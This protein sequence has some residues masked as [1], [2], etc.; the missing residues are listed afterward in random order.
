MNEV[1]AQAFSL[2]LY[3]FK[4]QVWLNSVEFRQSYKAFSLARR[5][6][7]GWLAGWLGGWLAGYESDYSDRSSF[8]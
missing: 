8:A 5:L 3:E 4:F 7:S 1:D 2:G 6:L